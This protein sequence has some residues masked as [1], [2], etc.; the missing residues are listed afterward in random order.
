MKLRRMLR[1]KLLFW[2][3]VAALTLLAAVLSGIYLTA[4]SPRLS[5]GAVL[6]AESAV[7]A[8]PSQSAAPTALPK[9]EPGLTKNAEIIRPGPLR[10]AGPTKCLPMM[11]AP[12]CLFGWRLF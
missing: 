3:A 1:R 4:I 9:G 12:S 5:P 6:L 7:D 2:A 10:A 11:A 8:F